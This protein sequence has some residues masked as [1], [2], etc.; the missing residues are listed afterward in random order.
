MSYVRCPGA[1]VPLPGSRQCQGSFLGQAQPACPFQLGHAKSHV[2]GSAVPS[3]LPLGRWLLSEAL[4]TPDLL[5]PKCHT[6]RGVQ[7][8]L[9]LLTR[10]LS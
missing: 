9:R 3:G 5:G 7:R 1:S 2:W 4:V 8:E 6:G 10:S